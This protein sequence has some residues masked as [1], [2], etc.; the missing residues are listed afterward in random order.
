VVVAVAAAG[1]NHV[2]LA[3]A[4]GSFY[5]G[6]PPLPSVGGSDGVGHTP[7]GR[8]VYFDAYVPQYGAWAG[9]TLVRRADVSPCRQCQLSRWHAASCAAVPVVWSGVSSPGQHRPGRQLLD[10]SRRDLRKVRREQLCCRDCNA[11]PPSIR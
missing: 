2:D 4:S 6:P 11:T 5:T 3:K 7:E 8:R 1:V 9:R 10:H